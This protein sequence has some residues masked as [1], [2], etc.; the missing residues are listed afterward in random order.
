MIA[1]SK[2][3]R[4]FA[5]DPKAGAVIDSHDY[6]TQTDVSVAQLHSHVRDFN[7]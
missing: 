2:F 5:H 7:L 3:W 6:S 1:L 4:Y